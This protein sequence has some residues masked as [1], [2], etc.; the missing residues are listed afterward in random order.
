MKPKLG[1][2][3]VLQCWTTV[4]ASSNESV[5]TVIKYITAIVTE[6]DLPAL[7]KCIKAYSSG[8]IV[9]L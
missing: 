5:D 6:R 9:Y 7:L 3:I 8:Y 1:L 2:A 4:K